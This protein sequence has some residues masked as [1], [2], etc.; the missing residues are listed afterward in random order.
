MLSGEPNQ[1]EVARKD[2][3]SEV[4]S[5][6]CINMA[7]ATWGG[8][9]SLT[10]VWG[11]GGR[12]GGKEGRGWEKDGEG[13]RIGKGEMEKEGGKGREGKEGRKVGGRRERR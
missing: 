6:D 4:A 12:E 13:R 7:S 8:T 1:S 3:S 5:G 10:S 11:G 9:P 2:C